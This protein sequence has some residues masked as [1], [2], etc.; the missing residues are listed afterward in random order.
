MTSQS[1]SSTL[2]Q[3][4]CSVDLSRSE[5][6]KYLKAIQSLCQKHSFYALDLALSLKIDKEIEYMLLLK[7]KKIIGF[8]VYTSHKKVIVG[9]PPFPKNMFSEILFFF[10]V[11]EERRHQCGKILFERFYTQMKPSVLKI[12][13]CPESVGF[14]KKQ[15]FSRNLSSSQRARSEKNTIMW[16][17]GK[18]IEAFAEEMQNIL[19][20]LCQLR[21]AFLT[22]A[23][24][25]E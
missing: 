6:L 2:P 11:P 22:E 13:A 9:A 14:W 4:I 16:Y 12:K 5:R 1:P 19:V 21:K 7:E 18:S 24:P 17:E 25:C 23:D 20:M 8:N 3:F 10:I 15:K